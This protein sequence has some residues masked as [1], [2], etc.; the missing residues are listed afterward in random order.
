MVGSRIS[1]LDINRVYSDST[2]RVSSRYFE[3]SL[4]GLQTVLYSVSNILWS[5]ILQGMAV[6]KESEGR[7]VMSDSLQRH[8][9]YRPEYWRI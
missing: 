7:L 8:G 3:V 2:W 5:D 1:E 4:L 6:R 9:L